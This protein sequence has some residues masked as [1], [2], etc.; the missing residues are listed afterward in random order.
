[1]TRHIEWLEFALAAARDEEARRRERLSH[2]TDKN[3]EKRTV[4]A[5]RGDCRGSRARGARRGAQ[6][7]P[8][9]LSGGVTADGQP[10]A[11]Q[12]VS[13]EVEGILEDRGCHA[14]DRR[15]GGLTADGHTTAAQGVGGEVEGI[16]EDRGGYAPGGRCCGHA[17]GGLCCGHAESVDGG[18]AEDSRGQAEGNCS[19]A[20]ATTKHEAQDERGQAGDDARPRGD[21]AAAKPAS[22]RAAKPAT[23]RRPARPSTS[24]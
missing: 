16:L 24:S 5:R 14:P 18:Q 15:C 1:M 17:P 19:Q 6:E 7:P 12:G 8:G 23:R 10:T 2:A 20:E 4:T 13:G 11:E 9:S 3:R 22:T 21:D